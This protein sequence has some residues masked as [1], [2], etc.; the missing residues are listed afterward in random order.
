M[1]FGL[2]NAG[3]TFQLAMDIAFRG[4]IGQS[5]VVYLDDVTMFSTK[6]GDHIRHLKKSFERCQKYGISS[7]PKKSIF[8]VSEGNL[9][10][11]IVSNSGIKFDPD[12]VQTIT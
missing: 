8:A 9:L 5:A 10:G 12:Q 11:H 3:A 6:Q 1:S 2:V 4:L 7:N